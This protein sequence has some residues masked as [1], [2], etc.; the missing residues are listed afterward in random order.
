MYLAYSALQSQAET[1]AAHS[2][3]ANHEL[4]LR[5]Q[6]YQTACSKYSSYIAEIQKY[7]PGWRPSPP[8]R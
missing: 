7:F 4:Q 6:A 2:S 3:S 1:P 8:V 5:Y